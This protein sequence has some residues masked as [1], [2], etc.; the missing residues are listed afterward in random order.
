MLDANTTDQR[1]L[2]LCA[3]R[4]TNQ[5]LR[6]RADTLG[7]LLSEQWKVR[8]ATVPSSLMDQLVSLLHSG[9]LTRVLPAVK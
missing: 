9:S 8:T 5:N 2:Y 3:T 6:M 7:V 1:C 4:V